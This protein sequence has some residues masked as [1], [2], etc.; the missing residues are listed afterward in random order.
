MAKAPIPTGGQPLLDASTDLSAFLSR[1]NALSLEIK[2][3]ADRVSDVEKLLQDGETLD[4]IREL[5][6]K[7]A[8][9]SDFETVSQKVDGLVAAINSPEFGGGAP[10]PVAAGDL[11]LRG[12]LLKAFRQIEAIAAHANIR[13]PG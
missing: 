7:A 3:V 6:A 10:A 1:L 4:E 8:P 5:L 2:A 11:Y 9:L 13:L 12:E